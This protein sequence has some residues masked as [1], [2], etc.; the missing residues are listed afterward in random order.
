MSDK[1]VIPKFESHEEMAEWFETHEPL[2]FDV[3]LIDP[4][5]VKV[6]L[7]QSEKEIGKPTAQPKRKVKSAQQRR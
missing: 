3:S 1:P 7:K 6:S 5:K 2:D 4:D